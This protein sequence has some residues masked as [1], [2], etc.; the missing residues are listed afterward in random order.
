MALTRA[1]N[2]DRTMTLVYNL[3]ETGAIFDRFE[4]LGLFYR[5]FTAVVAEGV[6]VVPIGT[7]TWMA[8]GVNFSSQVHAAA[9]WES[10][11]TAARSPSE[12]GG[13]QPPLR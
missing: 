2:G 5:R 12:S 9:T 1:P 13:S 4:W 10:V 11:L 3:P 8:L 6:V 7:W